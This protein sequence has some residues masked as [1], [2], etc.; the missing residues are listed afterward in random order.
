MA[1]T[2]N[3]Y[4][5]GTALAKVVADSPD[6]QEVWLQNLQ[7]A[8]GAASYATSGYLYLLHREFTVTSPGTAIF[9][10]TTGSTGFQIANYE[11]VSDTSNVEAELIEGATVGTTGAAIP[12]FNMN[13]NASDAHDATFL[14]GTSIS[15]GTAI[16]SEYITADK[17]AAGGGSRSGK[18]F[19]LEPSTAYAMKFVN[20]GNQDTTVHFQLAFSE[21]HA[22]YD[23]TNDINDIWVGDAVGTGVRVRGG[24]TVHMSLIQ[25]QTLSAI[26]AQDNEL[27]VTRQD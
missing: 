21:Q 12:A 15:G 16:A 3:R 11:I 14:A 5:V 13:R 25:G 24:E 8:P 6:S 20:R 18:I 27:M 1:V 23:G 19:T 4:T 7:P 9:E 2:H 17:H 22:G 26:A 10:L